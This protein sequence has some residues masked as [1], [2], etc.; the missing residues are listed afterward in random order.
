[1]KKNKLYIFVHAKRN[2][3]TGTCEQYPFA[4][5]SIQKLKNAI[6]KRF[7]YPLSFAKKYGAVCFIDG[8]ILG[9]IRTVGKRL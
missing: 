8:D 1:M 6:Q 2:E 3:R 5:Y 4:S 7:K 9:W